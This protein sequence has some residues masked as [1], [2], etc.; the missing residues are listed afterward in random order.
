MD[1]LV[2]HHNYCT[3]WEVYMQGH[4]LRLSSFIVKLS[5]ILQNLQTVAFSKALDKIAILK[6]TF[7][8]PKFS[9]T[10]NTLPIFYLDTE[11]GV[12]LGQGLA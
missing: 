4:V 2:F 8:V 1:P 11:G 6:I 5:P 9:Q 12:G 3:E 10:L 7:L